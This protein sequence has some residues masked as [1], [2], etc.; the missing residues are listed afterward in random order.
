MTKSEYN[1]FETLIKNDQDNDHQCLLITQRPTTW[2]QVPPYRRSTQQ[3]LWGCQKIQPEF[4]KVSRSKYKFTNLKD[5]G[6]LQ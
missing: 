3:Q 1:H 2:H 4:N 5:R 6:T